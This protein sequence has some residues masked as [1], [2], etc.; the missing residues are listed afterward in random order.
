M[1][2]YYS[3]LGA[4]F[5][6]NSYFFWLSKTVVYGPVFTSVLTIF[7]H[8]TGLGLFFDG[9]SFKITGSSL[10][11][12]LKKSARWAYLCSGMAI[13]AFI[14]EFFGAYVLEVWSWTTLPAKEFLALSPFW[15]IPPIILISFVYYF[16]VFLALFGCYKIMYRFIPHV[17]S[18]FLTTALSVIFLGLLSLI[19]TKSYLSLHSKEVFLFSVFLGLWLFCELLEY[20]QAKRG[21][22]KSI[23]ES[24]LK[25]L[26]G[27]IFS[28]F[29]VGLMV[30]SITLFF[31]AWT[32]QDLPWHN[33]QIFN[34]PVSFFL[35][36]WV[37]ISVVFLSF[38]QSFIETNE[39][40]KLF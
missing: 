7:L 9:L 39:K 33:I 15:Q 30:E 40:N 10:I 12:S 37:P 23:L 21:F 26:I 35:I 34:A 11:Y 29:T 25:P 13:L 19:M 38:Y 36:W 8:I 28:A 2:K 24:D 31:P 16:F 17:K 27:V 20:Q 18:K 3:A 6:A 1:Y 4:I 32:Y 14:S 22:L 5:L